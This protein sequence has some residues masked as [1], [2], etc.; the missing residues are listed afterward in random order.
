[1]RRLAPEPWTEAPSGLPARPALFRTEPVDGLVGQLSF[2]YEIDGQVGVA[3]L[4][5]M[6]DPAN[7][8]LATLEMRA[9]ED[10]VEELAAGDTV[11]ARRAAEL[12]VAVRQA[13][14]AK[15]N[16]T[17]RSIEVSKEVV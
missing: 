6:L 11:A 9:V 15:L 2:D 3:I 1:M 12:A 14:W 4:Y 10:A 13:R 7:N 16:T 8:A 5:P 17:G